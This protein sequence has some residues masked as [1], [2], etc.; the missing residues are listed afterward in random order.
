MAA[1]K[2]AKAQADVIERGDRKGFKGRNIPAS[3]GGQ[4]VQEQRQE[5]VLA[6]NGEIDKPEGDDHDDDE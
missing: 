3:A 5:E 2:K 6:G 4:H 1:R